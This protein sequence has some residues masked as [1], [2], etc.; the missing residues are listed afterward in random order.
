MDQ[1]DLVSEPSLQGS[2]ITQASL[3]PSGG[4]EKHWQ[5]VFNKPSNTLVRLGFDAFALIALTKQ[6]MTQ[7]QPNSLNTNAA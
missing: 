3:P 6:E 5:S 4:F 2:I 7:K 1:E